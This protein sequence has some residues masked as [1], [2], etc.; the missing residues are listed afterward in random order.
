M[1]IVDVSW[2]LLGLVLLAGG[3]E[4]LVRGASSLASALRIPRLII[5]LTIVSYGTGMPELFV[6]ANAALEDQASLAVGSVLGSNVFNVLAVLGLSALAMP[7]IVSSR[8][9][10]LDVPFMIIV[11]V[12]L[13]LLSLDKHLGRGDGVIMLVALAVYTIFLFVRGRSETKETPETTDS[14]RA[15]KRMPSILFKNLLLVGAGFLLL[16]LGANWLIGGATVIA[17]D[18]G[19]SELIIG[20]TLVAAGTS[21]PELATSI[22]ASLRGQQDLAVGNVVGSNI[23]NILGV[24]GFSS[25]ISSSWLRVEDA[26]FNFDIPVMIAVSAACLPIFFTGY[27]IVRWEGALFFGYFI[28][29]ILYLSFRASDHDA[30]GEFSAVM[31]AFAF[32]LTFVTIAVVVIREILE[33]RRKAPT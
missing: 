3:A 29:F 28:A 15:Q 32:P 9:V 8:L 18:I 14:S 25:L 4:L 16:G 11:S 24:L 13:L 17:R 6:G 7:L 12:G 30:L 22:T 33:K 31:I 20:L 1:S 10:R 26:A 5:G 2:V 23:F 21:M 27:A 19:V